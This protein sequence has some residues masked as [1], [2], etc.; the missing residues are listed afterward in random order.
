MN[1]QAAMEKGTRMNGQRVWCLS[2]SQEKRT[3]DIAPTTY[4]GTVKSCASM[5]V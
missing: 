3:V 5:L 4:M 1:A 2:D